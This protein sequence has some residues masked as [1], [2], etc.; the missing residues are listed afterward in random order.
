MTKLVTG[1]AGFIGFHVAKRLLERGERVIGIDNLNDY[2]SVA[3]KEA[4]LALLKPYPGFRFERA[5]IADHL[6]ILGIFAR[7]P[8]ISGIIHLAA[9]AGVRYSLKNP[10]AY[11][12]SN[13]L[14]QTVMLEAARQ[15]GAAAAAPPRFVYASSSS[16]YG[17]NQKQPFSVTDPVD[18][19][20]SLYAATKRSCE[21][22]AESYV[23]L[24]GL[25]AT[26]LRF[27]SV[28]GP[29]GRP[30]MAAYLFTDAIVAGRAIEVFNE[31]RMARDFTYIDD[32]VA[33]VVAALDQEDGGKPHKL[34]NLGNHRPER[35]L[36]FIGIIEGHL[37]RTA[38]KRLMP[39]QMG[40]VPESFAD[41]EESRR[42][43]GFEPKVPISVGLKHFIEW[44][45][46][47][48]KLA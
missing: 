48:H 30:D 43:L 1:A 35:L 27:F 20:V 46:A 32:I 6:A 21:L 47:Y 36:D 38:E 25:K 22:I 34:Y 19:P 4:R 17:G 40:D 42:D 23:H 14:G 39:L 44:Y 33:G 31:G 26:G 24:Y 10:Y 11:I 18:R 9:Q 8:D 12:E 37:G 16:V 7:N 2:Y 29:W 5:N 3:L 28:Y 13:V 15:A 41:I 45:K